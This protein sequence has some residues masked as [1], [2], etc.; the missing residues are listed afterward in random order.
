M[1][2][3]SLIA[4]SLFQTPVTQG[5]QNKF[6]KIQSE[7]RQL[8]Q[9]LKAGNL[10]QA[11]QDFA[12]LSQDLPISQPTPLLLPVASRAHSR[13]SDMICNQEIC[14]P[15]SAISPPFSRMRAQS[16]LQGHQGTAATGADSQSRAFQEDFGAL[17]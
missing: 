2:T 7:F 13:F 8:G 16:Q 4:N 5:V 14:R 10:K 3:I 17:R 15:R 12:T 6:Q 1:S 9:D 11:Q